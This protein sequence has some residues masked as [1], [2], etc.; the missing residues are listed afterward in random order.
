M[1]FPFVGLAACTASVFPMFVFVVIDVV[2]NTCANL[3]SFM[4]NRKGTFKGA[5]A[6]I[7]SHICNVR[8]LQCLDGN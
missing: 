2:W 4:R 1:V 6:T 5:R 7:Q 8:T 3:Y